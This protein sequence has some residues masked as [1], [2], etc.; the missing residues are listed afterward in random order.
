MDA[1]RS[2]RGQ[3]G[4]NDKSSI[5]EFQTIEDPKAYTRPITLQLDYRLR[6]NWKNNEHACT[7]YPKPE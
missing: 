7:D 3:I 2:P 4:L 5:R 6:P 1:P